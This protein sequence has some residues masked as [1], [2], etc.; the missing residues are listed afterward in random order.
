MASTVT[1]YVSESG[2]REVFLL[3]LPDPLGPEV[4]DLVLVL[5]VEVCRGMERPQDDA[6]AEEAVRRLLGK[7]AEHGCH[8]LVVGEHRAAGGIPARVDRL[9]A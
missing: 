3:P 5:P 8:D 1:Q 4:G 9:D 6:G 2:F 7:R